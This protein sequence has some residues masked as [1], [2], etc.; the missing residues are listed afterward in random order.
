V[1][2]VPGAEELIGPLLENDSQL[3]AVRQNSPYTSEEEYM[4][5]YFRLLRTDCFASIQK[6]PLPGLTLW[7]KLKGQ[8]HEKVGEMSVWGISL[9]PN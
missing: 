5:T 2:L 9:G 8:S 4:D 3:K 7:D 6:V 1:H